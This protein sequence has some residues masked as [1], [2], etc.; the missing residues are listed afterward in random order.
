MAGLYAQ[1]GARFKQLVQE[2]GRVAIGVHLAVSTCSIGGLYYAI[3][4]GVDVKK[5]MSSW[6]LG[7]GDTPREEEAPSDDSYFSKIKQVAVDG[8]TL[9]FAIGLNG[10][11]LPLRLPVTVGLTPVVARY[12]RPYLGA[13]SGMM[14]K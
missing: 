2:Y 9:A 12:L 13:G 8:G 4:H 6:G 14:K 1:Y 11:L 7:G 3:D 10:T 5:I